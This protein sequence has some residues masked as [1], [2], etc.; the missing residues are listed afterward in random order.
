MNYQQRSAVA[1]VVASLLGGTGAALAVTARADAGAEATTTQSESGSP[2]G[3]TPA[4][5]LVDSIQEVTS[6]TQR[7][8]RDLVAARKDLA[9]QV[10]EM[11]RLR[12][13]SST[14]VSAVVAPP[15]AVQAAPPPLVVQPSRAPSDDTTSGY[16]DDD[17]EDHDD[18]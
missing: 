13:Q 12:A 11:A 18:D 1:I 7:I 17:D 2:N 10:R 6:G 16:D 8:N 15:A 4:K 9:N 3:A 14:A 5:N